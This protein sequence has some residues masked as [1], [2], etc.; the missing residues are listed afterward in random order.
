MKK[1]SK[2][3]I[4]KFLIITSAN[5]CAVG[6]LLDKTG[7]GASQSDAR[8][9]LLADPLDATRQE[10]SVPS[11]CFVSKGRGRF[12]VCLHGVRVHGVDGVLPGEHRPR[13]L[14]HA[15]E[16]GAT[17]SPAFLQ[18]PRFRQAR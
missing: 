16:T 8:R 10:S 7:S 18:R 9:N 3:R 2:K 15:P 4:Y 13:R 14:G 6:L 17:T 1:K 5:L 12:H 11:T